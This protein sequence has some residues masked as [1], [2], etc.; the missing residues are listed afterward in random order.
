MESNDQKPI[1][2]GLPYLWSYPG[3]LNILEEALNITIIIFLA[4]M[5]FSLHA[6]LLCGVTFVAAIQTAVFMILHM[7]GTIRRSKL[8]WHWFECVSVLIVALLLAIF[9]S[10]IMT[11]WT[12]GYIIAG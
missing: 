10:V 1:P 3:G 5:G 4:F 11:V 12:R 6:N 8:A 9:A 2:T 7:K